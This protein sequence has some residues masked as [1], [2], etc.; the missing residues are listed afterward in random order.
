[1]KDGKNVETLFKVATYVCSQ[2]AL[3]IDPDSLEDPRD[4]LKL[5]L[6]EY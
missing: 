4:L 2:E 6:V 3:A 5:E 1:M